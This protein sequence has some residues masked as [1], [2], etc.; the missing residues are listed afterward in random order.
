MQVA[1]LSLPHP[2]LFFTCLHGHA[3]LSPFAC[4]CPIPSFSR[5]LAFAHKHLPHSLFPWPACTCI[6]TL[7]S[8]TLS[9]LLHSGRHPSISFPGLSEQHLSHLIYAWPEL[10]FLLPCSTTVLFTSS[11]SCL[12]TCTSGVTTIRTT[13]NVVAKRCTHWCCTLRSH[14][15]AMATQVYLHY[16]YKCLYMFRPHSY[17]QPTTQQRMEWADR[18]FFSPFKEWGRKNR[19][20]YCS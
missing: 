11:T 6:P 13:W 14:G 5:F 1:W 4:M 18:I 7:T 12:M 2:Q 3:L 15:L 16:P 8:H 9:L 10:G 20:F 19:K 17:L